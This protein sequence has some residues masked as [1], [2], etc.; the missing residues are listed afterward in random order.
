MRQLVLAKNS[1]H[2]VS[3]FGSNFKLD[4]RV[5]LVTTHDS[6]LGSRTR[7]VDA[8]VSLVSNLVLLKLVLLGSSQLDS[9]TML[10]EFK[11]TQLEW[12]DQVVNL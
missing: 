9:V 5:L 2:S 8:L 11:K 7:P 1:L 6:A 10:S 3:R 4:F 12:L